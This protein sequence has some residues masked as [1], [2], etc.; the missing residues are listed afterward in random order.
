[1]IMNMMVE[2]NNHYQTLAVQIVSFHVNFVVPKLLQWMGNSRSGCQSHVLH[3]RYNSYSLNRVAEC[4]D[5]C[6]YL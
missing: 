2:L 6:V 4:A 3:F 1:M 5:L